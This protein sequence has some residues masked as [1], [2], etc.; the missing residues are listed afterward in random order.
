MPAVAAG[1]TGVGRAVEPLPRAE[2]LTVGY[3]FG[4]GREAPKFDLA[5]HDGSRVSLAQFRGDWFPV[6]VFLGSDV[7]AAAAAASG[8][9]GGAEQLWGLRGQVVGI[10]HG[11]DEA[12][13]QVVDE[14]G[15]AEFPLLAD[16]DAA[17]ARAFGAFDAAA[18][19]VRPHAVIVD[20]AGKIAWSAD[21]PDAWRPTVLLA[22][23]RSAVR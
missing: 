5:A 4:V 3:T 7:A 20:R 14:A 1:M 21:G 15:R 12:A 13:R 10:V 16:P 9:N 2:V 11:D 23:L 6:V 17:V 19:V 22:A 8:L 18:A